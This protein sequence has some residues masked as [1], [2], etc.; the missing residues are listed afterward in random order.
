VYVAIDGFEGSNCQYSIQAINAYTLSEDIKNFTGWKNKSSN[1]I[2]WVSLNAGSKY[3]EIE[4]SIDGSI[5]T[6]VGT[7]SNNV[8]DEKENSYEYEDTKPAQKMWYRIKQVMNSGKVRFS[9]T[10]QLTR[11]ELAFQKLYFTIT[12]NLLNIEFNSEFEGRSELLIINFYGQ[13]ML[14]KTVNCKKGVNQLN[15]NISSLPTGNYLMVLKNKNQKI[16]DSF[17]KM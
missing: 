10:L 2:K 14:H 5:F 3:F 11:Q 15:S 7:I 17:T 13:Q 4:R 9:K 12:P 6:A 8:Q 16:C 1:L